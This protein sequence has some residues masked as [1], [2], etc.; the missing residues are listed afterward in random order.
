MYATINVLVLQMR[1][2]YIKDSN[3]VSIVPANVLAPS[4]V[5]PSTG[6]VVITIILKS[7]F[8]H[9]YYHI[10]VIERM[11]SLKMAARSSEISIV[12]TMTL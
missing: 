4:S 7:F 2:P 5:K 11:T 1:V 3:F 9:Q 8:N 12:I 10:S 6:T